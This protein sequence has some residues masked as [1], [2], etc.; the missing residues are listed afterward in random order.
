MLFALMP[1]KKNYDSGFK[2]DNNNLNQ[3]GVIFRT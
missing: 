2:V 1:K 3:T